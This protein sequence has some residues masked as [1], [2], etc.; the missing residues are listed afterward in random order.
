MVALSVTQPPVSPSSVQPLQQVGHLSRT[1]LH[2]G[3]P[4]GAVRGRPDRAICSGI[5]PTGGRGWLRR[6]APP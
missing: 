6:G 2:F 5:P 1:P 4:S 3:C